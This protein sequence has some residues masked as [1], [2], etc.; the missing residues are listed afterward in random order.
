MGTQIWGDS[1]LVHSSSVP[2][3]GCEFVSRFKQT[4]FSLLGSGIWVSVPSHCLARSGLV[5]AWFSR[6]GAGQMD[7]VLLLKVRGNGLR[8]HLDLKAKEELAAEPLL[9]ASA[10]PRCCPVPPCV[11]ESS[12]GCLDLR[13]ACTGCLRKWSQAALVRIW[14]SPELSR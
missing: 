9:H 2:F 12:R 4:D 6:R 10:A 13:G 5:L 1:L 11:L 3:L 14:F 7:L 8:D